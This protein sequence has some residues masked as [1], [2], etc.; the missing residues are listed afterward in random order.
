VY[1]HNT[2]CITHTTT[3]TVASVHY[4]TVAAAAS[5]VYIVATVASAYSGDGTG[6][7][8]AEYIY[9][10]RLCPTTASDKPFYRHQTVWALFAH[11]HAHTPRMTLSV[12]RPSLITYRRRF[13]YAGLKRN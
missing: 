5:R 1:A 11:W 12:A 2:L 4:K 3:A 13:I 8:A 10:F 6:A 7:T 9:K